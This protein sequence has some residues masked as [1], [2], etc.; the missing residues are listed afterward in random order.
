MASP[1]ASIG[2]QVRSQAKDMIKL[3]RPKTPAVLNR[4]YRT[5][6]IILWE[7]YHAGQADLGI[8][9]DV[10]GAIEVKETLRTAQN[11]KCAYCE[12]L[13]V[14]SHLRVEHFRPKNGWQQVRRDVLNKLGYFWLSYS[15]NNLL[16]SCEICNDPGHKG[17]IF[18]LRVGSRRSDISDIR[19]YTFEEPLL[20]D[21][22]QDDPSEHIEWNQDVPRGRTDRG[23]TTI[24][25]LG[26]DRD[27]QL[28]DARRGHLTAIRNL[29]ELTEDPATPSGRV[30][31]LKQTL[32]RSLLPSAPFLAMIAEN[33]GPRIRAL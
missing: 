32:Y 1:R 33:F 14:G 5:E 25:T 22:Y 16:Y 10:Y 8:K 11:G 15:W 9:H 17:N 26:L 2:S 23:T 28:S 27:G 29:L 4:R 20:I 18:P 12:C 13:P 19:C 31:Y 30:A 7:R 21:P 3:A 6:T 24:E